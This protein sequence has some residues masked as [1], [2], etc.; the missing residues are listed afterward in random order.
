[1]SSIVSFNVS[2]IV[3]SIVSSNVGSI[4]DSNSSADSIFD[5]ITNSKKLSPN[6]PYQPLGWSYRYSSSSLVFIIRLPV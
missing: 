2:S 1:M 4:V 3:N 5:S 6:P